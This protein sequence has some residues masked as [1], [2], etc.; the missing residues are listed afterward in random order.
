V[1]RIVRE[2]LAP[3]TTETATKRSGPEHERI[4]NQL[5]Y[6]PARE[7]PLRPRLVGLPFHALG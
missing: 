1:A 2:T 5:L 7:N 6:T 3:S 4:G